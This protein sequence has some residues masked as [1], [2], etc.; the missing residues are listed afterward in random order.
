MK[1][2]KLNSAKL[3]QQNN[4]IKEEKL[5]SIVMALFMFHKG[6][7]FRHLIHEIDGKL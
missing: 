6:C 4:K 2:Y 5:E 1:K 7:D 3:N